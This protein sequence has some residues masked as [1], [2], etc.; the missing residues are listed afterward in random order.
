MKSQD[1]GRTQADGCGNQDVFQRWLEVY[2]P[3]Y[4]AFATHG[5]FEAHCRRARELI[6]AGA[7]PLPPF[8]ALPQNCNGEAGCA[9]MRDAQRALGEF[10]TP[11]WLADLTLDRLG[12]RGEGALADPACGEGVFVRQALARWPHAD[13]TGFEINPLTVMAAQ[14]ALGDRVR[15][16]DSLGPPPRRYDCIAGN[17]PWVNWRR[18]A[19]AY[20][21]RIAPLWARYRLFSRTGLA[22]RLGGAMDDLSALFTYVWADQWLTEHGRMALLLSQTLFQSSGG[23]EAF[24]RFE[25]P[26]KRWLRIVRVDEIA[27]RKP[28][29][30]A[31]NRTVIAVFELSALPPAYPIPYFRNAEKWEARPVG[32]EPGSAWRIAPAAQAAWMDRLCGPSPYVGR[33]GAH[34]GGAAGVYRV[35]VLARNGGVVRIRNL[36]RAGRV[37]FPEC[38]TEVE[39]GL[40]Y[41]FLRG[42]DV[43]RWSARPSEFAL[44]PHRCDG[45]PLGIS[46]M[47]PLARAYFEQFRQQLT[48]RPH[49][50]RHFA[51]AGKPYWSMY[52]VGPYTFAE[53]R[54]AWREQ[55]AGFACAVLEGRIVADAKLT[56][57]PCSS[58]DEAHYLAA[59]L[60][61]TPAREFINAYVVPVQI[62]THV[63]KRL[64]IERY[65][66]SNPQHRQLAALSR[67]CHAGDEVTACE[68]MIDQLASDLWGITR[69][70]NS[71]S[72]PG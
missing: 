1:G 20:R 42:R 36:A 15:W 43:R 32:P 33:V 25:L 12:Y 59:L 46:E 4:G 38:E 17:P 11:E 53:H 72:A 16:G 63:L 23:G 6:M 48:A 28:F 57:V 31:Y 26:D 9:E 41:P 19:R 69:L 14:P 7:R 27:G 22:A 3:L 52:N 64:R 18:L 8:D 65:D 61:S 10:F 58:G 49:Y 51:G 60:N 30:N 68:S 39:A 21:D 62:S 55:S 66:P 54:V 2:R 13:V 45:R 29:A 71:P 50:R 56:V 35:E 40:V 37:V 70:R 47:P 67:R 34:T 44:I 5:V 24:R